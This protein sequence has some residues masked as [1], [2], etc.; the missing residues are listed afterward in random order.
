MLCRHNSILS[1]HVVKQRLGVF[2]LSV[3]LGLHIIQW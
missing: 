3:T 1:T 2:L